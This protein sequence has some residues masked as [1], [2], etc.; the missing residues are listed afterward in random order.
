[1]KPDL[2]E[3]FLLDECTTETKRLLESEID[4]MISGKGPSFRE[5]HFSLYDIKLDAARKKVAIFDLFDSDESG[6]AE[7]EMFHFRNQ[8]KRF[9]KTHQGFSIWDLV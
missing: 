9:T 6:K 5:H 3:R 8:L 1:M 2:V 4:E 7:L